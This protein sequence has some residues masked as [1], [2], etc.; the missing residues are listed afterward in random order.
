MISTGWAEEQFK[1]LVSGVPLE[2]LEEGFLWIVENHPMQGFRAW[3]AVCARVCREL[4][5][6]EEGLIDV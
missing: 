1:R 3:G 5:K 6:F 2:E 4:R